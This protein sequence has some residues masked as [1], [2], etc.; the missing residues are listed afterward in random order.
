[1]TTYSRKALA[2]LLVGVL[3]GPLEAQERLVI[4]LDSGREIVN[5]WKYGFRPFVSTNHEDGLLFVFDVGDPLV[6]MAISLDDGTVVGTYGRGEGEG[7]GELRQVMDVAVTPDGVLVSDGTRVNYW[8][9]DGT[10]VGSYRPTAGAAAVSTRKV[11][12]LAARLAVPVSGGILARETT[13][14]W[15]AIGP[16]GSRPEAYNGSSA[17][18]FTCFGDVAYTLYESLWE[19]GLD[20]SDRRVPIPPELEEASRRW[21]ESVRPPARPFP[22]GGLTHD[23]EGGIFVIAPSMG[24]GE[25]AGGIIDPATGCYQVIIDPDPRSRRLRRVE[26][27]Y[28]DSVI[29]TG[30]EVTERMINGVRTRVIDPSSAHMIALRPL[31]PDGGEPCTAKGGSGEVPG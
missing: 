20:G 19:Y 9:M 22:Y 15:K 10:L 26:G 13:G 6:A 18:H 27:V 28:R 5:D 2:G 31:R 24:R 29:V 30:S 11:C 23:G 14:S 7:P 3:G 21:R 4:D 8:R 16:G 25:V 12:S 17:T 1:M